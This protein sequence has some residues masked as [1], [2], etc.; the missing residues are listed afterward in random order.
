MVLKYYARKALETKAPEEVWECDCNNM[1]AAQWI[2]WHGQILLEPVMFDQSDKTSDVA[3]HWRLGKA[4]AGPS[5]E[6]R[7]IE[8]WCVWK[9]GFQSVASALDAGDECKN[10]VRN[11]ARVMAYLEDVM[12]F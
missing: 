2:L 7:S 10:V 1:A 12:L 6:P 9:A 3:H 5:I 4:Y 11:A 8:R